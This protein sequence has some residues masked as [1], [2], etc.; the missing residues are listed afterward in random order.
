M[1]TLEAKSRYKRLDEKLV[2]P[3]LSK[4]VHNLLS[5]HEHDSVIWDLIKFEERLTK[6]KDEAQK[7]DRLKTEFLAQMS[8]EIRTPVNS[9]MSFISLLQEELNGK[10]P[11]ELFSFF[12][13]IESGSR[14]LIRT[15]DMILD[16]SQLQSG[17]YDCHFEQINLFSDV[18]LPL[19]NEFRPLAKKKGLTIIC[20]KIVPKFQTVADKF[21]VTQIFRHLI[22]NAIKYTHYGQIEITGLLSI[23]HKFMITVKDT[24]KGISEEYIPHLFTPFSQEEMGY[25]RSY[26]GNG[27]GLA[28]VKKYLELNSA[29]IIVRSKK[30]EGSEFTVIFKD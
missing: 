10:I 13:N 30:S 26:E 3:E 16:M 28:L 12:D 17:S 19:T 29:E 2:D 18:I 14:R 8:H 9:I 1:F 21:S 25:T 20:P 4:L 15:I 24:G 6:A 7:S 27:L 23:D 11:E 5:S 22:D